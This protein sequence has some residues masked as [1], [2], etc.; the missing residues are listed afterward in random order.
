MLARV[1]A[2]GALG[3]QCVPG[4]GQ[5]LTGLGEQLVVVLG[6][7]RCAGRQGLLDHCN[8]LV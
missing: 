2:G 1:G 5:G 7:G 8:S 4:V 3:Q 6:V